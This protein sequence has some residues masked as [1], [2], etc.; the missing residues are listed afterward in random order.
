MDAFWSAPQVQYAEQREAHWAATQST[1]DTVTGE[2]TFLLLRP[3]SIAD[4]RQPLSPG[5]CA[6]SDE[7]LLGYIHYPMATR[8]HAHS[9][10][11]TLLD[12]YMGATICYKHFYIAEGTSGWVYADG[13]GSAAQSGS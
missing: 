1:K 10:I 2:N 6:W 5:R 9:V 13:A 4:N 12:F 3:L 7:V 11:S 8:I